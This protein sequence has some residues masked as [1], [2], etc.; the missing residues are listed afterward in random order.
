MGPLDNPLYQKVRENIE[1][2]K[3]KAQILKTK[4]LEIHNEKMYGKLLKILNQEKRTIDLQR[5]G[6]VTLNLATRRNHVKHINEENEII[7]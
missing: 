5:Q 2:T 4:E 3:K 7:S 6:P 1:A